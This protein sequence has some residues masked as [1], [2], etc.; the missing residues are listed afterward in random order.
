MPR[1]F[2]DLVLSQLPAWRKATAAS[3]D[4]K[5]PA[6]AMTARGWAIR[7]SHNIYGG[8]GWKWD[9]TANAWYGLGFWEYYAFTGDKNFLSRRPSR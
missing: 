4:F 7:T 9:K 5:T 3:P 1:P 8:M 2:F 6:G